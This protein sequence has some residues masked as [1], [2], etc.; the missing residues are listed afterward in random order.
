M[1]EFDR[2]IGYI[3]GTG[4]K[5]VE[6]PARTEEPRQHWQDGDPDRFVEAPTA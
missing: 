2:L 1:D 6:P 3:T 5:P 4:P